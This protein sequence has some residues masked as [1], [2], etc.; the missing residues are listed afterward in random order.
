MRIHENK[1]SFPLKSSLKHRPIH[2]FNKCRK[3]LLSSLETF[4]C[5]NLK[6][7]GISFFGQCNV[8]AVSRPCFWSLSAAQKSQVF[9]VLSSIIFSR[10]TFFVFWVTLLKDTY[11]NNL[12]VKQ[13]WRKSAVWVCTSSHYCP[14]IADVYS[15]SSE[16]LNKVLKSV[17]N[18]NRVLKWKMEEIR[19]EVWQNWEYIGQ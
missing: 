9:R 17:Q 3:C 14:S 18:K 16:I 12:P 15:I 1:E 19:N 8:E 7:V 13:I 10:L 6:S 5:R 11:L 4:F 2:S